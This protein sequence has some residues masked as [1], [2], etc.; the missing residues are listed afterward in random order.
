MSIRVNVSFE[1]KILERMDEESKKMGISRSAF[2]AVAVN[3]YLMQID[4]VQAVKDV[5]SMLDKLE[6]ITQFNIDD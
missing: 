3:Q 2:I 1:E 4:N 5:K 6:K